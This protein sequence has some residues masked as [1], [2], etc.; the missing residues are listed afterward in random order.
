VSTDTVRGTTRRL[1]RLLVNLVL[2]AVTLLATAYLV[3]SLMG[4]ERYVITGG[5]MEGSAPDAIAKGSIALAEK[6]DV[7]DLAV[8][9]VIT[10][11]PP[12]DSGVTELVTHRV[13]SIRE[14]A[15]GSR[16]FRTKGDA[17]ADPDPWR[18]SL[19]QGTQARVTLAVPH[20]GYAVIALADRETRI[21]VIGVPAALIALVS[22]VE[23]AA[24]MTS[25]R[26]RPSPSAPGG[27][28]PSPRRPLD[29]AARQSVA[30]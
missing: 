26:E 3:P 14:Q 21:L 29:D 8:G 23:A 27:T 5:S 15:D 19:D 2:V 6:A 10:Y 1:G 25:R 22:L 4:Y 30:S 18:F 24:A 7:A 11:Q 20:V 9:D 12:A 28:V 17:N 13:S 16:V